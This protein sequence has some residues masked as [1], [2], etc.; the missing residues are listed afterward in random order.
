M[1][2]LAVW[3]IVL[4][5]LMS[6]VPS[7]QTPPSETYEVFLVVWRGETDVEHGIRAHFRERGIRANFTL[8]SLDRDRGRIPGIVEEIR[9]EGPDLV[10]TWGTSTTLGVFGPIGEVDDA[11]NVRGIPGLFSLVAYP[12]AAGVVDTFE[13]TG[14]P[15][16]G[17]SFLAPVEAQIDAMRLYRPVDRLG[18]IYNPLERNSV[19]NIGFLRQAAK[20]KS[21]TLLEAEVPLNDEGKPNPNSLPGLV[22]DL[23]ERGADVL[24]LGPDSFVGVNGKLITETAAGYGIP[25][26]ATTEFA[27][28][29]TTAMFGLIGRYFLIGKLAG[30]LAERVLVAG[31]DPADIPVSFLA[32]Y[33][34]VV[35]MPMSRRLRMY[36][37]IGLLPIAEIVDE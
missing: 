12:V 3:A 23:A 27:F 10:H 9:Q 34:L 6:G 19:L 21:F 26:F 24:Y 16:S 18:V 30:S 33:S 32:R 20:A 5:A 14:R 17:T 31:E 15:I 8:R 28:D 1:T 2:R 22:A 37:P 13:D 29:N 25:G 35:R 7:A 36:P 4:S 11:K